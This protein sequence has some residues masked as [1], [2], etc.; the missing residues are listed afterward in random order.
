MKVK[1]VECHGLLLEFYKVDTILVIDEDMNLAVNPKAGQV[2]ERIAVVDEKGKAMSSY[3]TYRKGRVGRNIKGL[4][5]CYKIYRKCNYPMGSFRFYKLPLCSY[6][7][8]YKIF[9]IPIY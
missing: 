3:R 6:K 4:S 9:C 2:E 5:G 8:A 7:C 1:L